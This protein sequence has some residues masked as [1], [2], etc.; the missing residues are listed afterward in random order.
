MW[1]RPSHPRPTLLQVLGAE[2]LGVLMG[3]KDTKDRYKNQFGELQVGPCAPQACT[4]AIILHHLPCP[5]SM[6]A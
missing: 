6:Q 5:G 2:E 1:Y 4:R 3:I